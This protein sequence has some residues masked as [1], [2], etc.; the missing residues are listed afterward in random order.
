M[1]KCPQEQHRPRQLNPSQLRCRP[2]LPLMT[3]MPISSAGTRI[4]RCA[5][6]SAIERFAG[7][8]DHTIRTEVIRNLHRASGSLRRTSVQPV[9]QTTRRPSQLWAACTKLLT[10]CT[11]LLTACTKLRTV[12][13]RTTHSLHQTTHSP[14][15]NTHNHRQRLCR[16]PDTVRAA[17]R[18]TVRA[19]N[20]RSVVGARRLAALSAFAAADDE[21]VAVGQSPIP[22]AV[23]PAYGAQSPPLL[24]R[25]PMSPARPPRFRNRRQ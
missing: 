12:C 11:K 10:A 21:P 15:R 9:C 6:C 13:T 20:R 4:P 3:V 5:N 8:D 22:A 25:Q 17:N 24:A 16:Q 2:L 23:E 14:N 18:H 19:A 1:H 7:G